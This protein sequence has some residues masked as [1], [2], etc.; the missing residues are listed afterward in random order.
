M[1]NH[2]RFGTSECKTG[3][4]N[5][6]RAQRPKTRNPS[7]PE[8]RG[9]AIVR[10]EQTAEGLLPDEGKSL[11]RQFPQLSEREMHD[12]QAC[13]Y[14]ACSPLMRPVLVEEDLAA[15]E[16]AAQGSY[17]RPAKSTPDPYPGREAGTLQGKLVGHRKTGTSEAHHGS[18]PDLLQLCRGQTLGGGRVTEGETHRAYFETRSARHDW[19]R[20]SQQRQPGIRS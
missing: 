19:D 15:G 4:A 6:A 7:R 14:P 20:Q 18:P 9:F 5:P 12:R 1:R 3:R 10:V 11:G 17:P 13:R 8:L 2:C 16:G